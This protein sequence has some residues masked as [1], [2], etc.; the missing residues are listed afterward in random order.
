MQQHSSPIVSSSHTLLIDW[1]IQF[2]GIRKD[3]LMV[4]NDGLDDFVDVGLAGHLVLAVWRRHEC[5]AEA[6]GQV[7][8]VHHVLITVLRQAGK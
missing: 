3:G 1:P 7:V 4:D 2:F 8:W 5:G 6:Y